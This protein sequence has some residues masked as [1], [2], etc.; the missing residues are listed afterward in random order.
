MASVESRATDTVEL[1]QDNV[2]RVWLNINEVILV[3]SA[4]IALEEEWVE[5]LRNMQPT[6]VSDSMS[7]ITAEMAQFRE[8]LN[9]VLASSDLSPVTAPPAS[10]P[11]SIGTLYTNTG[12]L[13][14]NLIYY[15]I[16]SDSLA[17]VA[18]Y[19]G[20]EELS[21]TSNKD[22]MAQVSLASQRLDAYIAETGL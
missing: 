2:A 16:K 12:T 14:D 15:L 13:L 19:Y 8:K 10:T 22:V 7:D 9:T 6:S 1:S 20:G 11:N 21:G 3:L 4:N 17:S 18:I 5:G